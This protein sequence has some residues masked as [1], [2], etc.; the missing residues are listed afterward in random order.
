MGTY[1]VSFPRVLNLLACLVDVLQA[2]AHNPGGLRDHFVYR[3]CK[4]EV[5]ILQE[6]LKSL[7]W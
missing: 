3:H 7:L 1:G 4:A 2:R 5:T 6:V